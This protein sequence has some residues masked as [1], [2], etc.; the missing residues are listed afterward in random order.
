MG[1]L[2]GES[3][4][5]LRDAPADAKARDAMGGSAGL[6][7]L[8][9]QAMAAIGDHAADLID[10][11]ESAEALLQALELAAANSTG[12]GWGRVELRA[13]RD[14]DLE[15]LYQAALDL[16]GGFRWRFRGT[17]PPREAFYQA[18]FE[19]TLAQYMVVGSGDG[20]RY[21][22]VAAYNAQLDQ[23]HAYVAFQRC[24]RR[25]GI[26]EVTE[27]MVLFIDQ[28]F[29]T[30][31]LRKLYCEVPGY[32]EEIIGVGDLPMFREEGRL[33]GH[34]FH[35]GRWWDR[36]LLA[37]WR[38]DWERIAAAPVGLHSASTLR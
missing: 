18:L 24:T 9:F 30:L 25:P 22:L 3:F 32:N 1:A 26:S 14:D 21:G 38:E 34:D 27:G 20:A 35:A 29:A 36:I 4:E 7:M 6:A 31:A 17:T 11:D 19:G 8:R 28:L 5:M 37:L 13:F 15:D 16:A 23:G 2:T 12:D 10:P 33:V